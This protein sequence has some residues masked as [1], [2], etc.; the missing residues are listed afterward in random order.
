M[1]QYFVYNEIIKSYDLKKVF[2]K[3]Y[4]EKLMELS[5]LSLFSQNLIKKIFH[6][7]QKKVNIVLLVNFDLIFGKNIKI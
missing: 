4:K 5:F 6:F 3:S 2:L 1:N 7:F